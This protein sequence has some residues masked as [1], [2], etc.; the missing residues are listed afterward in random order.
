MAYAILSGTQRP[1]HRLTGRDGDYY[2]NTAQWLL[3][4]PKARGA[5]PP[6]ARIWPAGTRPRA[7]PDIENDLPLQAGGGTSIVTDHGAVLAGDV[8]AR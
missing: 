2:V 8:Q 3:Y 1:P 7:L 5:W 4:G 6:G